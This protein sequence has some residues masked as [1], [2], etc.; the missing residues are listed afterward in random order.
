MIFE[1]GVGDTWDRREHTFEMRANASQVGGKE[2]TVS[3]GT[4]T[5]AVH[6]RN[7]LYSAVPESKR[8]RRGR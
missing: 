7:C 1:V 5:S 2:W 4:D 6:K 3:D 8:A